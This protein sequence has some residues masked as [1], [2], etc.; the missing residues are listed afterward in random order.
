[1]TMKRIMTHERSDF[2]SV[3]FINKS[4]THDDDNDL[5]NGF[6]IQ[7]LYD[8]YNYKCICKLKVHVL[9]YLLKF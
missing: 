8:R 6:V 1:M 3:I 4:G 2:F 7:V 9:K 5:Y